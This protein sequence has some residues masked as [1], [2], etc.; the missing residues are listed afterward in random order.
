[1]APEGAPC[2]AVYNK[3]M[4]FLGTPNKCSLEKKEL[5][6]NFFLIVVFFYLDIFVKTNNDQNCVLCK[7]LL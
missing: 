6:M 2:F 7:F 4:L 5:K 1:M 3:F